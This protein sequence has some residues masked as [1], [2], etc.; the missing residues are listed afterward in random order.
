[1]CKGRYSFKKREEH[2][3]RRDSRRGQDE[4]LVAAVA[5]Y[6]AAAQWWRWRRV[7]GRRAQGG[8]WAAPDS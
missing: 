8:G 4:R 1:M 5:A 2:R 3:L 7:D 6:L